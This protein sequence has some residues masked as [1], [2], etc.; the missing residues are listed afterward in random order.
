[1][2]S[3]SGSLS[4]SMLVALERGYVTNS[5]TWRALYRRRLVR[6]VGVWRDSRLLLSYTP[7]GKDVATLSRGT[8]IT[9]TVCDQCKRWETRAPHPKVSR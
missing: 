2:A 5:N 8:R 4:P 3:S 6:N 7:L 1:M 9:P